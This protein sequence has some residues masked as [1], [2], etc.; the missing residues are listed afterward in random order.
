MKKLLCVLLL[1]GCATTGPLA[2]LSKFTQDDVAQAITMATA[3]TDAGAPYRLRCY[4][5]LAKHL[6]GPGPSLPAAP[7][8]LVS[9]YEFSAELDAAARSGGSKV[10]ADIHADCAVIG[11]SAT[12]F[13]A[14]VGAKFA[15]IPGLGAAG[16]LLP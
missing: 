11:L 5:T 14:R 4:T 15:P 12:E 9:G 7:K 6:A 10:P 2:D 13:A 3:A 8:G 16:A 1:G